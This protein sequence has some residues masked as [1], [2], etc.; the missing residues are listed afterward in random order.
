MLNSAARGRATL[1]SP[2]M[3]AAK[4]RGGLGLP[5]LIEC[6]R[7]PHNDVEGSRTAQPARARSRLPKGSPLAH[8]EPS[9]GPL[10]RAPPVAWSSPLSGTGRNTVVSSPST[11]V[12]MNS[13]G[14]SRRFLPSLSALPAVVQQEMG[15][16]L[17][18][19]VIRA[20]VQVQFF[21]SALTPS[22]QS[23]IRPKAT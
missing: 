20:A 21:E 7:L 12:A 18:H 9:P 8:R 19:Q 13:S 2:Q 1:P 23:A 6:K 3:A 22:S 4:R 15:D 17:N 14:P 16:H 11:W 5:A 10:A